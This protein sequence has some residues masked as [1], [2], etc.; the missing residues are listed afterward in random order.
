MKLFLIA[1]ITA[2]LSL[3][4]TAQEDALKDLP[5][6][7]DFNELA[8]V[9]GEPQVNIAIGGTLLNFVGA[10]AAKED[11]E[12]G[13]V[14]S[15]LKGVRVSTYATGGNAMTAID[16]L[17]SVKSDLQSA[18]WMPVV[19]VNDDGEHVQIFLKLN[20]EL[21]DGL[22]LMAVDSEEAVFINVLGNIDPMQLSQVMANFD[23]DLD[24]VINLE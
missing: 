18:N 9:Y 11:P 3:P 8:S 5:G 4:V 13:P 17:T 2:F 23:V 16:E 19:Q 6:Y 15:Q 7:I 12:L 24:P 22:V 10:M 20:G 1:V 21:I 14:F